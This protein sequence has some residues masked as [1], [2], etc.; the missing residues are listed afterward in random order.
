MADESNKK[1]R[2][3]CLCCFVVCVTPSENLIMGI[4]AD[5]TAG[6]ETQDPGPSL[7]LT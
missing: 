1:T 6:T 2:D 5:I 4:A 3:T 7:V